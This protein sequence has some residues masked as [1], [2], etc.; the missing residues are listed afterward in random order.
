M[1]DKPPVLNYRRPPAE[2]AQLPLGQ[3]WIFGVTAAAV[4]LLAFVLLVSG[5]IFAV[6]DR[7]WHDLLPG[8]GFAG[9]AYLLWLPVRPPRRRW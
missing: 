8:V 1:N 5:L 9:I 2:P 3:R 4:A 7:E 6:A